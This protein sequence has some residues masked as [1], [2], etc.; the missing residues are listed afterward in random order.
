[1][2]FSWLD[3]W[4]MKLRGTLL[5][6]VR[7]I[8]MHRITEMSADGDHECTKVCLERSPKPGEVVPFIIAYGQ[9]LSN[10]RL[11][12]LVVIEQNI[13]LLHVQIKS[14]PPVC[15]RSQLEESMFISLVSLIL[16]VLV[17]KSI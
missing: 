6:S 9:L 1:M 12:N 10:R 8:S 5:V 7:L 15:L 13:R 14:T 3:E 11:L 4:V 16:A 17:F 2:G